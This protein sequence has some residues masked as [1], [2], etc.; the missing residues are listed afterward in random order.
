[1]MRNHERIEEL[2]AIRALGG[3][4]P[5]DES[6]LAA[7]MA[8]HGGD[9]TECRRLESEY[10]E[11]A[12][13]LAFALDPV[14]VRHGLEDETLARATSERTVLA[15]VEPRREARPRSTRLRHVAI[16][17]AAVAL[18]GAGF[19]ARS[20]VAGDEP[21]ELADARV[22]FFE[23]EAGHLALAYRP[24]EVGAHLFG[25]GLEVPPT[26]RVYEV[27]MIRDG[28][29]VSAACARPEPDGTL[30]LSV[31]ERLEEAEAVAVTIEP[32]SC[33]EAPTSE[34]ILVAPIEAT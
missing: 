33:P 11:T 28:S 14:P 8:A 27:W 29:P 24:G 22:V 19:A 3:L 7:E 25:K 31:D 26:D 2:V 18:F 20:L 32:R 17:A 21:I 34:P 4:D 23:G 15:S 30:Q 16:A 10:A 12:G 5:E 13:R 9:C 6:A 1:M